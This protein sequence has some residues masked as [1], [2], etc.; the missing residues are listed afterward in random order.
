MKN[1]ISKVLTLLILSSSALIS[2]T[3]EGSSTSNDSSVTSSTNSSTTSSTSSTTPVV[4]DEYKATITFSGEGSELITPDD[5]TIVDTLHSAEDNKHYN[6]QVLPSIGDVNLLVIPVLIPGYTNFT[7][8]EFDESVTEEERLEEVRS[9]IETSFFGKTEETGYESVKSYYYKSSFGKLNL[10]GVVTEWFDVANYT[11]YTSASSITIDATYDI[12]EAAVNWALTTQGVNASDYD[13]DNDGFIDGVW[14][15]YSAEDYAN[16]GPYTD[17]LNYWAYTSWG[18]QDKNPNPN[19][20]EY[21]YNLFGWASYDFMYEGYGASEVDAHTF[22]HETG[23]FLGLNDYY[24]DRSIYNPVGKTDMMDGNI[25][26]QNSYSK[27]LLGWTKPYIATSGATIEIGSMEEEN[28]L[29]VVLPDGAEFDGSFDPFS[30]YL[31]IELYTPTG[32]NEQDSIE[33]LEERPLAPSTAGVRVYHIDN[34]RFVTSYDDDYSRYFT[35]EYEGEKLA[36]DEAFIFPIAN[37]I[38]F[39]QY[40]YN[41]NVDPSI[42]PYDEI[43][44]IEKGGVNTFSSGGYQKASTYFIEGDTFSM[45]KYKDFFLNEGIFNNKDTLSL[46]FEVTSLEGEK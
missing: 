41:L 46:S 1:K 20:N 8:G 36:S 29:I 15:V 24:S 40:Y 13:Y 37:S 18:N 22:I 45:E 31:L 12:A 19:R 16:N 21:Y 4:E 2:C 28:Q 11:S 14:L 27:M 42:Y 3:T 35:R 32:L 25:I 17:D 43:R 6:T 44:M 39:D 33:A 5:V 30:E 7:L 9:D 23:H 38:S 10:G 26:D 34:R